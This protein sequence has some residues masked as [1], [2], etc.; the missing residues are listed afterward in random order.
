MGDEPEVVVNGMSTLLTT[1]GY[2]GETVFGY[3]GDVIDFVTESGHE[4]ALIP[5]G[6]L[7]VYV[8][9]TIFKKIVC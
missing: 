8:G 7:L 9:I 3:A 1:L 6:V 2:V 4:L 5:V